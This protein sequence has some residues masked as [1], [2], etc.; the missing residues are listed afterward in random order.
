MIISS[1]RPLLGI[2][3]TDDSY[4]DVLETLYASA[5]SLLYS[6]SNYVVDQVTNTK[7][8]YDFT[9]SILFINEGPIQSITS[10][11]YNT[12]FGE[13][14]STLSTDYYEYNN[15]KIHFNEEK[16]FNKCVVTYVV[17]ED[18]ISS[19]LDGLLVQLV[20]FF[21]TYND[22]KTYLSGDSTVPLKPEDVQLPVHLQQLIAKYRVV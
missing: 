11:Q 3:D 5:K 10:I 16:T 9:D 4:D 8:V 20:S 22:R 21:F 12:T 13:T 15:N 18:T 1:M 14:L 19:E 6:Y 7:T 17:G 2:G